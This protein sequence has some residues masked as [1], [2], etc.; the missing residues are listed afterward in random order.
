MVSALETQGLVRRLAEPTLI[1][2]SGD[3]ASFLAGGEFPYQV[4]AAAGTAPTVEFKP[5]GVQLAFQPTV[6]ANG[7]INLRLSPSVSEIDFQRLLVNGTPGLSKREA[8]TTVELRDGQSFAIAGLL[9]D[10]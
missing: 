4:A 10:Q 2:L 6:L 5:F 8:R 7:V 1:A 9:Q 3:S